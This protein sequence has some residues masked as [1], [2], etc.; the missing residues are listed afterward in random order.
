MIINENKLDEWVRGNAQIAQGLIVELIYRLIAASSPKP[1]ERRFPLGDSIGQPGPD[2]VLDT[3]FDLDPFVPEGRSYWEIGTGIKAGDK[4]TSDYRH[5]TS[6]TPEE[7]RRESTF[8]FVTPLSGRKDWDYTWEPDAQAMW[9]E[10]RRKRNEWK[11]VRVLDGTCLVDWLKHFPSVEL[12]LAGKMGLNV[13]KIETLEQ[14]WA[15]LKDI[16][17]PP[18][19]ISDVFL[20]NREAAHAKLK[21]IFDDTTPRLRLDTHYPQQ[22]PDF[23][24]ACAESL[25]AESKM[26]VVGRCLIVSCADSWNAIVDSVVRHILVADF[27]LEDDV[28]TKLLVKARRAGHSVIFRGSPG[29]IP[30]PNRAPLLNPKINEINTALEKA[31]YSRERARILS[32]RC[33]GNLSSLLRLLQNLSI[34]PEWA[35]GTD[36]AELSI[37]EIIGAWRE[38]S[39]ADKAVVEKISG[40]EYGEWIRIMRE[41]AVR[42]ST[43]LNHIDDTW[44]FGARYEGWYALGPKLFDE[45]LERMKEVAVEVLVARDPKFELPPDK[46]LLASIHGK[47]LAH[48]YMLRRGLAESLAFIGSHPK[49][50]T[51]TSFRR[52]ESVV[53]LAV[54][55][56]LSDAD[57]VL[58]AS[59]NDLLPLLAEAAPGEFLDAVETALGCDPCPF[60]LILA[61]EE[62]GIFGGNYMHGLLW[63]LETLAWDPDYLLRVVIVLGEL[64]AK[65][66]RGNWSNQPANSL[67]T[68]FLPWFPQTC[69]SVPKRKNA[70]NALLN[71]F[72]EIAWNLLLSLLPEAHQI[73]SGSYKPKWRE[74]IP[75]DWTEGATHQEYWEQI[76]SYAELTISIAKSDLEKLIALIGRLDDLPPEARDQILSYLGS[77]NV[78]S[79]PEPDRTRLWM[80]LVN[81]TSRHRKFA[82]SWWAMKPEVVDEI[83]TIT[84][85]LAPNSPIHI[86]QRLFSDRDSD[87]YEEKGD[88]EA[89]RKEL[90]DRRQKA[91][92]EIFMSGGTEEVLAFAKA[93]E[94]PWR[95]GI[96]FGTIASS[97]AE[98]IMLPALLDSGDRSLAQ[99]VGG[100]IRRR[101]WECKWQWVDEV[102]TTN[103]TPSQ[104]GQFFAFLPFTSDTWERVK[105][106]LGED[107]YPYWS[108]TSAN[109][110]EAEHGLETAIDRLVDYGRPLAAIGC[111]RKM[112]D[113]KQPLNNSQVVRVFQAMFK[114]PESLHDMNVHAILEIVKALQND[115]NMNPDDLFQ[116]EWAFIPILDR[117]QGAYPK[118]LEHRL[119]ED[120]VFFCEV[121]RIVFKSTKENSPIEEP[122]EQQKNMATNAY[123]LLHNWRM[124]PGSHKDGTFDGD[125]LNAWLEKV[126]EISNESGHLDV[127]L[128]AVGQ[129]LFHAPPDPN[130][131]W[132]H[133]SAARVL[134]IKENKKMR[135]GFY[136]AVINSRGVFTCTKGEEERTIA[137]KYKARAEELD[138]HGYNRF[139]D[140]FRDLAAHYEQEAERE[141]SRENFYE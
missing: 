71:E 107:E 131:F 54:H 29:G 72:P 16:G 60:D 139:A 9:I 100:F 138:S 105:L 112:V 36:A 128:S 103:W 106:H 121:I 30:D 75:E 4:A 37:A 123:Y 124:P 19:L 108:K 11:N 134:N 135:N 17:S 83:E 32:Q 74:T 141:A 5:L 86:H 52:A 84:K 65:D 94:S 91:I 98:S 113:E 129:V 43:P 59:L 6:T 49:V 55:E 7:I 82:E 116:I 104:K 39:E 2:G 137:A 97:E 26:D 53:T 99:F 45:H 33:D 31:G 57:W 122:T 132:I 41:I 126:K 67:S 40:K 28:G 46:R 140:T 51:S 58:W 22:M 35:Q 61:Q 79:L 130:G 87:L 119:A 93:V 127:S 68:I 69:A 15:I 110:Y 111:V 133:H 125:T 42:P 114:S 102:D 92:S 14:H 85:G 56:I 81:L 90:D 3:D 115:P 95:V 109:P 62:P 63:A 48:S 10:Q 34:M 8:I 88:W 23:V 12:W 20:A 27:D 96:A 76:S 38:N 80:E 89:Q 25:D 117:F 24:S 44:K 13:Q 101:F 66:W 77:D 78:I 21:E 70:I 64:A 73:S 50:L 47:V 118:L 136:T 120:P 1:N 18:P